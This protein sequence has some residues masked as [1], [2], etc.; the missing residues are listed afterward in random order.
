MDQ[1]GQNSGLQACVSLL[2]S[3]WW[4]LRKI[5]SQPESLAMPS[6]T[7]Q[8]T[9]SVRTMLWLQSGPSQNRAVLLKVMGFQK[10]SVAKQSTQ[11]N[12]R[13]N[14]GFMYMVHFRQGRDSCGLFLT[15]CAHTSEESRS[16]QQVTFTL[17]LPETTLSGLRPNAMARCPAPSCTS[18]QVSKHPT[19]RSSKPEPTIFTPTLCW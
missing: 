2:C 18:T 17:G 3:T 14:H 13:A 7:C 8:G 4:R 19:S 6:L 12:K 9:S 10:R 16:M 15:L 1:R 5:R 11:T